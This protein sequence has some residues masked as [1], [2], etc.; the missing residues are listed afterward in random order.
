MQD[1]IKS[2]TTIYH[3]PSK[4]RLKSSMSRKIDWPMLII[5]LKSQSGLRNRD[6]AN[7]IGMTEVKMTKIVSEASEFKEADQAM[8]L[9][10]AYLIYCGVT[11]PRVGDFK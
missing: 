2:D 10:D 7:D 3:E 11:P 5:K 6:I 1:I 8:A 9:L 4:P